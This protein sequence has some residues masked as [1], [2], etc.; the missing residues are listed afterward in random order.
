MSD[1]WSEPCYSPNGEPWPSDLFAVQNPTRS[2]VRNQW[3]VLD[4]ISWIHDLDEMPVVHRDRLC[5]W[6]LWRIGPAW[7][8]H[9]EDKFD[10]LVRQLAWQALLDEADR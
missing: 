3:A 10:R 9:R 1:H 8:K 4:V 2:C 6:L 5:H 7:T